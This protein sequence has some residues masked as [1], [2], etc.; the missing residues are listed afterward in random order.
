MID[1]FSQDR[2][3]WPMPSTPRPIAI[4]GAG[5]IVSGGHLPAYRQYDLPVAGIY[6]IDGER[7]R[8]VADRFDVP[9]VY[10]T[11]ADLLAEDAVFDIALPPAVLADVL[12]QLPSGAVALIQKPLG[13]DGKAARAL[14][15]VLAERGVTA[16]VNFQL[17]FTPA[18]VAITNAIRD[19][20][21]GELVDIDVNLHCKT[22]WEDWPFMATMNHIE[23]PLHSIHYLDWIRAHAGMPHGVFARSVPH[24]DYPDRADARSSIILDYDRDLKCCLSL[25]HVHKGGTERE[26][27]EFRVEGTKAA[28]IVDM[29]YLRNQ[30]AGEDE[31][32]WVN[33]GDGWREVPLAGQRMVD[34]FAAVMANLQRF[35][36]GEDDAL[37]TD[38]P[39]S[40]ATMELVDACIRSSDTRQVAT[41]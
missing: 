1:P 41:L 37:P 15:D 8:E 13:E 14:A 6:D 23:L 5:G 10:D 4:V 2:Q 39:G 29:G 21:F 31:H 9:K 38:I 17:R 16:S 7:A 28:A 19:G 20:V 32:L 33:T 3:M 25:S 36:A 26:R 27:G 34:S 40:V 24:P 35:A 12:P 18:M 11:L 22:P 30:P